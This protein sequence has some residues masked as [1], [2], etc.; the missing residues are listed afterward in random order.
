MLAEGN[1]EQLANFAT[2]ADGAAAAVAAQEAV[3][4]ARSRVASQA[5]LLPPSM[6]MAWQ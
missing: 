3:E 1:P 2:S 6:L 5:W 4:A